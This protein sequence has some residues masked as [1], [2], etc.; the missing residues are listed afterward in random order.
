MPEESILW[1]KEPANSRIWTEALPIGNGRMGAMVFGGTKSE[2]IQINEDSI[3]S[4][5]FRERVNPFAKKELGNI[6]TLIKEKK[7]KE[8]ENLIRYAFYG[9]PESMCSYQT[10][11]DMNFSFHNI[12]AEIN[13][14]KRSLCLE[15]AIAY[16]S[17]SAEGY[18]YNWEV[19]ASA[20]SDLISIKLSTQN[21]E[22]ICFDV[23]IVRGRSCI[24]SGLLPNDSGLK[25]VYLHGRNGDEE[26]IS[27]HWL[28]S[29][30]NTGGEIEVMGEYL[31]FRNVK[32]A[33]LYTTALSSFRSKNTFKD[34]IKILEKAGK[35]TY[36]Q[37]RSEHIL[38]YKTLESRV[39]FSLGESMDNVLPTDERLLKFKKRE[40][41]GETVQDT[42]L[43]LIVL[44]FRYGRYLLIS[45]SRPGTLPANLQGI[46]CGEYM[47]PWGSKYTIN[48]N[49]EMNYWLAEICNLSECHLPLFDHLWRMYPRGKEIADK[50]YGARG[51][52]AHH[53]TDIWG[54]CAPH[55][56]WISG[57]AWVFGAAWLC[58]H[59]WD[60]Y[61]YTLDKKFLSD[62]F[63][64]IKN[65]CLFFV[66]HLIENVEGYLVVSPSM[67]PENAYILPDGKTGTLVE[68]CTMDGQILSE[69]FKAFECACSILDRDADLALKINGMRE[70]LPHIN[71]GKNGSVMEWLNEKEEAEPGHR[72]MSHLFA[73]FPGSL[74][75]RESTPELAK[76]AQRTLELRLSSGGGHTGWSRAWIINF[77]ARLG[78]GKEAYKHLIELLCHSTLPNLFDDHPPFQIDGNFGG[79]AGIAN[80]LLHSSENT[81]H[82][83]KALPDEWMNGSVKGFCAKGGLVLDFSWEKG[84]LVKLHV[85]ANHD[86]SGILIYND[87]K[88]QIDLLKNESLIIL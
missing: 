56:N 29:A 18:Q 32:E 1:Y 58:L 86:Y 13:D 28:L 81:I 5:G 79:T 66:D 10:L 23:R 30:E 55:G 71:I 57:T 6:R 22:G 3:W 40:T 35:K 80:M 53:N 51:F 11:G 75:S 84:L 48:I 45:C 77:W 67:S 2:R 62:H 76:A 12:T 15:E 60:H 65:A 69:L 54:D 47:P 78:N 85:T 42:D 24:E 31:I 73:L 63:D 64:L 68:G 59:I 7:I 39:S 44:Y 34:C 88:K 9:T 26:G 19:F 43:G 20:P 72:H 16:T 27:F 4:E 82:L 17:F 37:I 21:P 8:A 41:E 49:I 14:Y 46:W 36:S 87:E 74:V 70:K 50:M 61:E 38:D 33:V 83:L 25:G 52:V